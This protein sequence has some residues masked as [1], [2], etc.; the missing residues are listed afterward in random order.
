MYFFGF[1]YSH[2]V[3]STVNK[4]TFSLVCIAGWLPRSSVRVVWLKFNL[5]K[6]E[7]C[8]GRLKKVLQSS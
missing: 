7:E 3:Q 6:S 8:T 5:F 4:L 1:V 2:H